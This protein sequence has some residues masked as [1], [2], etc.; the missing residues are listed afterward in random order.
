MRNNRPVN[1]L[2]SP[3]H[4]ERTLGKVR[5]LVGEKLQART[6]NLSTLF[7]IHWAVAATSAAAAT[8]TP[9]V[10]LASAGTHAKQQQQPKLLKS[11][12][13]NVLHAPET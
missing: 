1:E 2:E 13:L 7:P 9:L 8:G 3:R 12:I 6:R 5:P 11:S 4:C 10:M